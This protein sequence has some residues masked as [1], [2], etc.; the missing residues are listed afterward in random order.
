MWTHLFAILGLAALCAGWVLFQQWLRQVDP[1][2]DKS[3][4]SCT[5]CGS[6]R[7]TPATPEDRE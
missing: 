5:G 2:A 3:A 1:T 6:C 7:H 4:D